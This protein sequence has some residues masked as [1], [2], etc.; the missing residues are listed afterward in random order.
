MTRQNFPP[1][2]AGDDHVMT[3]YPTF[4]LVDVVAA[5]LLGLDVKPALHGLYSETVPHLHDGL[6]R[7]ANF[8]KEMGGS[9]ERL[10]DECVVAEARPWTDSAI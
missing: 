10:A 4:G 8:P 7:F 2:E 3:K 5:V 9:C 1:V 6:P